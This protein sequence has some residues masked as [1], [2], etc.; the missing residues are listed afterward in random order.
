MLNEYL[1]EADFERFGN[2]LAKQLV[3]KE[4]YLKLLLAKY[5]D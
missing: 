2:L 4:Q 5:A 1:A 3:D